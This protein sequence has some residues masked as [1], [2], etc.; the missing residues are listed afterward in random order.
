MPV[1]PLDDDM[2]A[3]MTSGEQVLSVW[4]FKYGLVFPKT[5]KVA[6]TTRRIIM[7]FKRIT[8]STVRDYTYEHISSVNVEMEGWLKKWK[9]FA[10][11]VILI[12]VGLAV[13]DGGLVVALVGVAVGVLGY[14]SLGEFVTISAGV[15]KQT[16]YSRKGV[17]LGDL[18]RLIREQ[19]K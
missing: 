7:K 12:L 10:L 18:L 17:G 9:T 1:Q 8:A 2:Q 6:A 11:A 16:I 14:L 19:R 13:G 5:T 4:Q 15:D 3:V